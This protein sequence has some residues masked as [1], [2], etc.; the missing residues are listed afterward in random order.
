MIEMPISTKFAG[1]PL[2]EYKTKISWR[3]TTNYA[4]AINDDN[5]NYVND[6]RPDGIVAHPMFAAAV[7]WPIAGNW[8]EFVTVNDFPFNQIAG[9]GV[10]YSEI[11][12]IHRLI[13]PG[14]ELT[15]KSDIAAIL[16]HRAGTHIIM[17]YDAVDSKGLPVFTEYIGNMIRGV[18]CSGEDKGKEKIPEIPINKENNNPIWKKKIEIERLR[19]FIYDGCT[20]IVSIIHT[21]VKFAHSVDLPDIILQGSATI[22]Y[23]V[24]E[25]INNEADGNPNLVKKI[26][27]RFSAMVIPGTSITVQLNKKIVQ[28]DGTDLFFEVLNK[29]N[30]KAVRHGYVSLGTDE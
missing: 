14:D 20:D 24:R 19:P 6:E 26:S 21:S 3:Q 30:G 29:E 13:K 5:P 17:R 22:A 7:T 4:A 11:C 12:E 16:S 28:Q 8:G 2:R 25:I 10:H 23:A 9:R 27:C 1:T 15:I 18:E